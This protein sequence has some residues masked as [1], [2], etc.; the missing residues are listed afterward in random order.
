M[1]VQDKRMGLVQ[2]QDVM[3]GFSASSKYKGGVK[4][5]YKIKG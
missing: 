4:C 5:K 2:V 1:Q 3:E